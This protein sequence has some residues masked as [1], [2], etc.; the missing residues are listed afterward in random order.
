MA[1]H[2]SDSLTA[3]LNLDVLRFG[4]GEHAEALKDLDG[5]I[6]VYNSHKRTLTSDELMAV[7]TACRYLGV[8][9][10]QLF[11][12]ALKAY[13]E[14]IASDSTNQE[15]HISEVERFI[16]KYRRGDATQS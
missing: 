12:D 11:K 2:A 16:D 3:R 9:N 5:F 7:G 4:R 1:G 14:A 13:D 15:A 8:T 6:D 10:P